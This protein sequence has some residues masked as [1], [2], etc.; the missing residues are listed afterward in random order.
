MVWGTGAG[1][2]EGDARTDGHQ[3]S[4]D[5]KAE[6][7]AWEGRLG[8]AIRGRLA[9]V[10]PCRNRSRLP[11]QAWQRSD[12]HVRVR[13]RAAERRAPQLIWI[14]AYCI[15]YTTCEAGGGSS[16]STGNVKTESNRVDRDT[17][18][19]KSR[20]AAKMPKFIAP[21]IDSGKGK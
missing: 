1:A 16:D 7:E 8:A 6:R 20:T 18:S 14:V 9:M 19:R 15:R 11:R 2:R 3:E 17:V 12:S 21:Q 13:R 5:P 4:I 10:A